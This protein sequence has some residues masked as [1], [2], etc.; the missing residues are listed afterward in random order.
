MERQTKGVELLRS[1]PKR[2]IMKLSLPMMTAMLVQALYNLVDTIWVSG[3]GPEA[4]AGIG[5]FFPIFMVILAFAGGIA[6]GANSLISRKVGERNKP[7]ADR[8][9]SSAIVL[10]L[11]LGLIAS[12][13]GNLVM[14]PLL[15]LTGA[16]GQTLK[17]AMDYANI[18]LTS[19]TLLM[20][21]NVVNG[22][23]RGEGDT[24]R[25]MYAISF[26]AVLNMFLDPLFIYTFKL[27]VKGA[28]YATVISIAASS[29]LMIHWLFIKKDTY[30]SM[31]FRHL[32]GIRNTI[33]EIL[34]VGV[35]SSF[36]QII[37]STS[38]FILNVFIVKAGG[39]LGVAIFT[40]A[41]RII[42]FGTIPMM[43]IAAAV[44][45][46]TGAAFGER[47]AVKLKSAYLFAVKFGLLVGLCVN[48]LV[49]LFAP[50]LALL[51]TY[52]ESSRVIFD[53]LVK[54]LRVL[55]FFIPT[56]PFGM[57]T[58][59]MFQGI[60][61]AFKGLAVSILRTVV[62]HVLFSYLFV[63]VFNLGLIGVWLGIL[64]GNV[65]AEAITFL[66]GLATSNR[67][68]SQFEAKLQEQFNQSRSI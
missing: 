60:G 10:V 28:A 36:A 7:E 23:L 47:N 39:D 51:F 65:V 55:S 25:A 67:L 1:D 31:S 64:M 8:A 9:A 26:G 57:F 54:A 17:L 13:A 45:S 4:L 29:M 27:G 68:K 32:K 50:K 16:S 48:L 24:K 30:V 33:F 35:P 42:N 37:M 66:W 5:L 62:L 21:N 58:S 14:K 49:L 15:S 41:W 59:A 40:S 22:I 56:V 61:H 44:T 53:D 2:A 63:F 34:R 6:V 43:G 11:I 18:L 38:I 3:V 20:F 19:I 46:V 52:S 12:V